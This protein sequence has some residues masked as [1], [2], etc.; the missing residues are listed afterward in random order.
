[1]SD[2][3]HSRFSS[4]RR[5]DERLVM[6][7][8]EHRP[9]APPAPLDSEER[10]LLLLDRRPASEGATNSTNVENLPARPRWR[11]WALPS[12]V[13]LGSLL[14]WG[15]YRVS[16]PQIAEQRTT[17][18][19]EFLVRSWDGLIPTPAATLR[20]YEAE[21]LLIE[22]EP[23]AVGTAASFNVQAEPANYP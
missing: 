13:A 16:A 1:M 9:S 12:A 8:Q 4:S 11:L 22:A 18:L 6:F 5:D 2:N 19:E 7:L 14:A 21:W 3:H 15:G 23:A 17:E 20:T 10:L